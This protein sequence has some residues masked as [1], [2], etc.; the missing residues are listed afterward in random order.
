[1]TEAVEKLDVRPTEFQDLEEIKTDLFPEPG[2]RETSRDESREGLKPP[3][4]DFIH[5][6]LYL[7]SGLR[8]LVICSHQQQ[9]S[10]GTD[11]ANDSIKVYTTQISSLHKGKRGHR[12]NTCTQIFVRHP[13]SNRSIALQVRPEYTIASIKALVRRRIMM[14]NACFVLAHSERMLRTLNSSLEGLK[15]PHNSTLTCIS[16]RPKPSSTPFPLLNHMTV[17]IKFLNDEK[18]TIQLEKDDTILGVK[19]QIALRLK[20]DISYN[21]IML[22]FAGSILKDRK[23]AFECQIGHKSTLHVVLHKAVKNR[24]PQYF[25]DFN[26]PEPAARESDARDTKSDPEDQYS[27]LENNELET[28]KPDSEAED[29]ESEP[30]ISEPEIGT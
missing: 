16:F 12:R 24:L 29:Q 28:G 19:K 20:N 4:Q 14:P 10:T 30:E 21:Q 3:V 2:V 26:E 8:T 11:N 25:L 1:M 15:V 5:D 13:S 9:N 22:I 27:E 18:W 6:S 17:Y 23:S 7:S